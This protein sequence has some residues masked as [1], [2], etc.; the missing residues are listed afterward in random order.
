M[1]VAQSGALDD[2]QAGRGP[3]GKG[4][5]GNEFRWEEVMEVRNLHGTRL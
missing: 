4:L 2:Q 1:E 3:F 5:L